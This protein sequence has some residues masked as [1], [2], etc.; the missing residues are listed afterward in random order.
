M[1]ITKHILSTCCLALWLVACGDD[2]ASA[3]GDA[4]EPSSSSPI[5][6]ENDE[7][8]S[9]EASSSGEAS[10]SS[11]TPLSSEQAESSSS[12]I[13]QQSSSSTITSSAAVFDGII[14][15]NGDVKTTVKS[16]DQD[17]VKVQAAGRFWLLVHGTLD[18]EEAEKLEKLGI[19]RQRCYEGYRYGLY[20]YNGNY[21]DEFSYMGLCLMKSEKD[22]QKSTIN[23]NVFGFYNSFDADESVP[24]G[25]IFNYRDK[26]TLVK[27]IDD[28][29][30][31]VQ[32]AGRFWLISDEP[33]G[34]TQWDSLEEI[35]VNRVSCTA[36]H[37]DYLEMT[38]C[39]AKSEIDIEKSS[40]TALLDG[41]YNT[42]TADDTTKLEIDFSNPNWVVENETVRGY[43]QCWDD[44]PMESCKAIVNACKAE[45]ALIDN[46]VVIIT[47]SP[48]AL[49]CMAS[50]R[51]ITD[52]DITLI[53]DEPT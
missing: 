38:I 52:I 48:E 47:A 20:N 46:H 7:S 17:S 49:D 34:K 23:S 1:H 6:S 30:T 8:S 9:S 4:P 50:S 53:I 10:S 27:R 11:E 31:S 41:F 29:T 45:E 36:L 40:M 5:T 35:G 15:Q 3:S 22:V 25:I 33:Y 13:V 43:V 24:D 44:V 39:L 28:D 2:S 26:E 16:F 14:I 32:P 21:R 19:H 37:Q 18:K 42:F 51:D 12:T